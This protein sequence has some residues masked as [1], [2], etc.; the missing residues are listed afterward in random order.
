MSNKNN[1]EFPLSGGEDPNFKVGKGTL[2]T[3]ALIIIGVCALVFFTH[4]H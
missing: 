1:S 3:I 2:I 4:P